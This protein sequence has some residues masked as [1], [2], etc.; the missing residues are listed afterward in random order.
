MG[1]PLQRALSVDVDFDILMKRLTGRRTCK[2]CNQMYNI[3]FSAPKNEAK[4]D[5]CG[6]DLYQRDDDKE[7]T[8]KKRL[9][10]YKA[11]TEPLID[12]YGGKSIL[13][14]VDGQGDINEIFNKITT[15]L[16]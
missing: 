13:K 4:C 2:G 16:S 11:Q 7:D 1:M 6:G 12:Y 5:K 8:I 3:F 15:M 14:R 10:V 9:D